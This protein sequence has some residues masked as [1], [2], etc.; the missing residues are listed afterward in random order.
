MIAVR[1]QVI[2][3]VQG[4]VMRELC[5]S[6]ASYERSIMPIP[7]KRPAGTKPTDQLLNMY[8]PDGA[9]VSIELEEKLNGPP[10]SYSSVTVRVGIT[11]RCAQSDDNVRRLT[12]LLHAEAV[13]ALEH[14]VPPS[15]EL[16]MRHLGG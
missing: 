3:T 5:G 2:T 7:E 6:L 11:S 9:T 1:I 4:H 14:H 8:A 13:R 15:Q 16:L 12:R 10:N